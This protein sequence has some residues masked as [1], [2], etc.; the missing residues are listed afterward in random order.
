MTDVD[1]ENAHNIFHVQILQHNQYQGSFIGLMDY[2]DNRDTWRKMITD[3]YDLKNNETVRN[4]KANPKEI[5]KDLIIRV[6]YEGSVAKWKKAWSITQGT[7]PTKELKAIHTY[8]CEMNPELFAF[9][10]QNNIAKCK[11]YNH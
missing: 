11:N 2:C 5:S 4:K 6:L 10:K 1:I 7:L 9:C 8:I 3:A